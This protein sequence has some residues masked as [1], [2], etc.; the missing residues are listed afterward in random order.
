VKLRF[1]LNGTERVRV[2][3]TR[4]S[5][6]AADD[7]DAP[8]ERSQLVRRF[9]DPVQFVRELSAGYVPMDSGPPHRWT[10]ELDGV[11]IAELEGEETRPRVKEILV[12]DGSRV[13]FRCEGRST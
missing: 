10:I 2:A 12:K 1:E 6:C 8:H 11:A 13:H 9:C 5:I 4:D 7:V 3:L